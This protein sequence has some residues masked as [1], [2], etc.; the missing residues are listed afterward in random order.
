MTAGGVGQN[1]WPETGSNG[2]LGTSARTSK[3][4]WGERRLLIIFAGILGGASGSYASTVA[5][6]PCSF[7]FGDIQCSE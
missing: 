5:A 4:K 2:R 3:T 1:L 7:M 6:G